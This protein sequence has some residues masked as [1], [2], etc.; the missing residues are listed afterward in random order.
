VPRSTAIRLRKI[1]LSGVNGI[2]ADRDLTLR[3]ERWRHRLQL[4]LAGRPGGVLPG[5]DG[6]TFQVGEGVGLEGAEAVW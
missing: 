6:R 1:G 3:R 4:V 5:Q 2:L